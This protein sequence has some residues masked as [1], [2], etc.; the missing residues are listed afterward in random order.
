MVEGTVRPVEG[1]E[2]SASNQTIPRTSPR[3]GGRHSLMVEGTARP[4]EKF[5]TS[6]SNQ[7]IPRT[8][9]RAAGLLMFS[10]KQR[11]EVRRPSQNTWQSLA[12]CV[13]HES[14]AT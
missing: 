9:P 7:S 3:A 6:T 11:R 12:A 14:P 8:S 2:T 10:G 13:V 4:V 1:F 5:E